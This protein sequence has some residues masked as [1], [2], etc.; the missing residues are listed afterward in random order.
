M[1][2]MFVMWFMQWCQKKT[3]P[4]FK[5]LMLLETISGLAVYNYL[6][7]TGDETVGGLA[8]EA[9]KGALQMAQVEPDDVDLVIV[10]TSTPDD[11][12]GCGAQVCY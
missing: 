12:F 2:F 4:S 10:C 1:H 9:A 11:L 3:R 5:S 6:D 8:V 7:L